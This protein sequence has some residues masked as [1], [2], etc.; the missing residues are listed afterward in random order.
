MVKHA[1]RRVG[2]RRTGTS[3]NVVYCKPNMSDLKGES[4][5][6]I[7]QIIK[8][9][10]PNDRIAEQKKSEVYKQAILRMRGK[11]ERCNS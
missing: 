4:G 6:A 11:D 2:G 10:S 7:V 5:K 3:Q 9:T 1:V 8:S